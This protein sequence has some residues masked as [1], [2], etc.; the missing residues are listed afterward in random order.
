[1]NQQHLYL[2]NNYQFYEYE[3]LSGFLDRQTEKGYQL[4][5]MS[6]RFANVLKFKKSDCP[7][8]QPHIIFC[9]HLDEQ[10]DTEIELCKDRDICENIQFAVLRMPAGQFSSDHALALE[11]QNEHMSISIKKSCGMILA[12][13]FLFTISFILKVF[14]AETSNFLSA[15]AISVI[16][17]TPVFL[18]FLYL[19]GDL[20]DL[21][22][23]CAKTI[24]NRLYFTNRTRFKNAIFS[25]ADLCVLI[26]FITG[27]IAS[28]FLLF[29][30]KDSVVLAELF[31]IW[32]IC[33]VTAYIF[34]LKYRNSYIYLLFTAVSL[35]VFGI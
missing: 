12:L 21:K 1:M 28:L 14:V 15:S 16:C 17:L 4:C 5:G 24:C 10:I 19:T 25:F 13:L 35:I 11:K 30:S 26:F 9:K 33:L 34:R 20:Y 2:Y 8:G 32:F 27:T 31:Q 22:N 6:G 18:F 3:A 7:S 29:T 23:G